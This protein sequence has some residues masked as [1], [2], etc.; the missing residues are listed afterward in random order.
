[1]GSDSGLVG[2]VIDTATGIKDTVDGTAAKRQR[3]AQEQLVQKQLEQQEKFKKQAD[4]RVQ[5]E[6]SS[7]NA[8]RVRDQ[9]KKRQA[10]KAAG[11]QGR[12]STILTTGL[13]PAAKTTQKTL[14]GA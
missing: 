8:S 7:E 9:A 3:E 6:E 10:A 11:N 13:E 4:E 12:K 5:N 2:G 14:L 1:M